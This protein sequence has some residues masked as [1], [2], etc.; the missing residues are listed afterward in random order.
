MLHLKHEALC[1]HGESPF[2]TLSCPLPLP[3][4][5][6]TPLPSLLDLPHL[7]PLPFPPPTKP[8]RPSSQHRKLPQRDVTVVHLGHLRIF[9]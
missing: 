8:L 4:L 2:P 1:S 7:S 6:C 5:C 3:R 9:T